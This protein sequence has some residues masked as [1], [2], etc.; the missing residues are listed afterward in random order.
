MKYTRYF[1]GIIKQYGTVN[2]EQAAMQAFLNIIHL[3]AELKVYESLNQ[4]KRFLLKIAN[5]KDQIILITGGLEPKKFMD[6]LYSG[7]FPMTSGK[8]YI[9]G[10]K[11]WDEFDPYISS[12][13]KKY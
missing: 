4:D 11:T 1:S 6:N 7:K 9:D 10:V 2:L 8:N 5:L 13:K 3:E 12:V